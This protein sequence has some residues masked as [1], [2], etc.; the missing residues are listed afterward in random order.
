MRGKRIAKSNL[1][2]GAARP[3]LDKG[4]TVFWNVKDEAY[5]MCGRVLGP[6]DFYLDAC[7]SVQF[8]GH[9]YHCKVSSLET[10]DPKRFRRLRRANQPLRYS[11]DTGIPKIDIEKMPAT[12]KS[13]LHAA[14][15]SFPGCGVTSLGIHRQTI[16]AEKVSLRRGSTHPVFIKS[17]ARVFCTTTLKSN[18]DRKR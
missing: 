13:T 5:G 4:T 9:A 10:T 15:N 18:G 1:R 6:S 11:G 16:V 17:C 14:S 12:D 2:A 3:P 7:V 8:K